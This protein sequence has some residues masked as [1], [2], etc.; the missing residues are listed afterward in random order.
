MIR[1][2][3]ASDF[4]AAK[5]LIRLLLEDLQANG[6]DL[7]AN[8]HN[9]RVF[10]DLFALYLTDPS[11][12]ACVVADEPGAGLIGLDLW[13]EAQVRPLFDYKYGRT[14]TMWGIY[15]LAQWRGKGLSNQIRERMVQE[16]RL[17]GFAAAFGT[18]ALENEA[19]LRSA[20]RFGFVRSHVQ[21]LLSFTNLPLDSLAE[22]RSFASEAC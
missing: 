10:E 18:I 2:A 6:G 7:Q 15:I 5:R 22:R 9:R 11:R 3:R 21:I 16:L 4:P 20:D 12:G 8:G 19:S 13:G 17:R 1:L 14:A